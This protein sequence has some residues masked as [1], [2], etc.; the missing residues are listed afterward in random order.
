MLRVALIGGSGFIG[1]NLV[2]QLQD[3]G[4]DVTVFSITKPRVSVQFQKFDIM[5]DDFNDVKK[6]DAVINLAAKVN[7]QQSIDNPFEAYNVN[8]IGA[9][10]AMNAALVNDIFFIQVGTAL[11]YQPTLKPLDE[12]AVLEPKSP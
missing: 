1:T 10:R 3:N 8:F 5:K 4:I 6:F 7:V 9:L 2:R 11:A 12:T